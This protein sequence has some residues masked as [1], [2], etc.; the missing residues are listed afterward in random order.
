MD[1]SHIKIL[2]VSETPKD[3]LTYHA[4]TDVLYWRNIETHE[5]EMIRLVHGFSNKFSKFNV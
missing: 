4:A 3:S 1:G 5:A 2:L